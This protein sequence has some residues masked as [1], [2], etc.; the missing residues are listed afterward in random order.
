MNRPINPKLAAL[1]VA[2]KKEDK[3]NPMLN[4]IIDMHLKL[5]E[6]QD[7]NK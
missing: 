1:I 5:A 2:L 4:Q 3:N 6:Q 7:G